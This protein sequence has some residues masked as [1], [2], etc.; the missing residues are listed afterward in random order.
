[1]SI[2]S[3]LY[4]CSKILGYVT[5]QQM[6]TYNKYTADDMVSSPI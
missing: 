4:Y 3:K 5:K 1:M 6:V 2:L